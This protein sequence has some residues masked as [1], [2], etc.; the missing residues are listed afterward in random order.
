MWISEFNDDVNFTDRSN[1]LPEYQRLCR[2]VI[3]RVVGAGN[4]HVPAAGE[5]ELRESGPNTTCPGRSRDPTETPGMGGCAGCREVTAIPAGELGGLRGQ[6]R[7]CEAAR[8]ALVIRGVRVRTTRAG[9]R[10]EE[11]YGKL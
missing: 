4:H 9:G 7:T 8:V 1:P 5:D 11:N 10:L 2:R 3:A 6:L